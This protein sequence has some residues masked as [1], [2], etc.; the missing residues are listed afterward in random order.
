MIT[1]TRP[2]RQSLTDGE[3]LIYSE[4]DAKSQSFSGVNGRFVNRDYTDT[5]PVIQRGVR[6][7]FGPYELV[8]WLT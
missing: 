7:Q 4:S 3:D 6:A 5:S 1:L 8:E 2:L